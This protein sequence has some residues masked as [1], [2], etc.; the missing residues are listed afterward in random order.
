MTEQAFEMLNTPQVNSTEEN[1]ER[2]QPWT[3]VDMPTDKQQEETVAKINLD[4]RPL[5]IIPIMMDKSSTDVLFEMAYNISGM[6]KQTDET[7][8]QDEEIKKG[9]DESLRSE[10]T[11]SNSSSSNPEDQPINR[12]SGPTAEEQKEILL[13]EQKQKLFE[14][15][16]Q[17]QRNKTTVPTDPPD[18][19]KILLT[20]YE[21]IR[22]MAPLHYKAG[23]LD[24]QKIEQTQGWNFKEYPP[25]REANESNTPNGLKAAVER[26]AKL[27]WA[28][29]NP[30]L[31]NVL[32]AAIDHVWGYRIKPGQERRLKFYQH[33][34]TRTKFN[35]CKAVIQLVEWYTEEMWG[36]LD[37]RTRTLL[38]AYIE[39]ITGPVDITWEAVRNPDT[40]QEFSRRHELAIITEGATYLKYNDLLKHLLSKKNQRYG[41]HRAMLLNEDWEIG[42]AHV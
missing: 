38:A 33:F 9:T 4:A 18:A 17:R 14:P 22:S 35:T 34:H 42:R 23:P 8:T 30:P 31:R 24:Q 39:M 7:K 3:K 36:I 16:F 25:L 41:L 2:E 5:T 13:Q 11:L 12:F 6:E 26:H 28:S 15:T 27:K 10:E 37:F 29:I 19:L 20:T 40:R 21:T 1:S 32:A